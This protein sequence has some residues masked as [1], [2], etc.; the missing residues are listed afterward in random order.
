MTVERMEENR[1]SD[2]LTVRDGHLHI[3]EYDAFELVKKFGSPIYVVSET[4]LRQNFRVWADTLAYL[5]PEGPTR[6]LPSV[7]ANLAIASRMV[8]TKEGAGCDVFGEGELH[9]AIQSGAEPETISL[10]GTAKN[11]GLLRKAID[12]GVR[13]TIDNPS[14]A[15]VI[16]EEASKLGKI[17]LARIRVRFS[18][19]DVRGESEIYRGCS[20][21]EAIRIYKTGVPF[22]D[23]LEIGRR[24]IDSPHADFIGLHCHVGRHRKDLNF[25]SDVANCLA[26]TV[27]DYHKGLDGWIPKEIDLGGGYAPEQDPTAQRWLPAEER[28]VRTDVPKPLQYL[29]VLTQTIRTS[30]TKGGIS[31][32][33]MAFEIEPGRAIYQNTSIHLTEVQG[34]K[35]D[36]GKTWVETDTSQFGLADRADAGNY[37]PVVAVNKMDAEK[38]GEVDIVGISC[39]S[40]FLSVG[41]N[42][43][44][45]TEGDVIAFL[46]TGAYL[47][48]AASNFNAMPRP[49]MVMVSGDRAEYIKRP[50]TIEDVFTR[51]QTPSWL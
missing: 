7:K 28:G 24:L 21:K 51:D 16:I 13:I 35:M 11:R 2:S 41:V 3:E 48:P 38:S 30:L 9:A 6:V 18:S 8:L 20:V 15:D 44:K 10:N 14:E 36:Q 12:L 4:T 47:E 5:W 26:N 32:E 45:M 39:T 33:G 37:F 22:R 17:A 46:N 29:E 50:E 31:L 43:P 27:I 25:W 23:G 40:D 49:A 19:I 34:V 1:I 42:L